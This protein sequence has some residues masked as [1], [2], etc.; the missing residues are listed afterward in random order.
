MVSKYPAD[1]TVRLDGVHRS[2]IHRV[3]KQRTLGVYRLFFASLA[4]AAVGVQ[5][6]LGLRRETF[7]VVNFFSFFTIESNLI[8]AFTFLITGVAALRLGDRNSFAMLQGLAT[9]SMTMTG[10]I[11]FLL[12]RGLEASLQTPVPWVNTVL[13]YVMP[14]AVLADW[15]ID[16]PGRRVRFGESLWWVLFPA[17]Y[18]AY[19]L[20]R[21]AV[22]GWY[23]Y[24]FLNPDEQSYARIAVTCAVMLVA[25]V[26]LVALLAAR[27]RAGGQRQTR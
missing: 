18:V 1:S 15:L 22:V 16:P 19:S 2:K 12:L 23:P 11:Y 13:H 5:L 21:G 24:P 27:T 25:V 26:G 4:L 14:L 3:T 17:A 9:L 7:D 20:L 10:I 6:A 8:A